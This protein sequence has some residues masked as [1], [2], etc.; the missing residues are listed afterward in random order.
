MI[1]FNKYEDI[2]LLYL[3]VGS[4]DVLL[5]SKYVIE[6][7]RQITTNTMLITIAITACKM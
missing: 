3:D 5:H 1:E 7:A 6:T 4:F 2:V